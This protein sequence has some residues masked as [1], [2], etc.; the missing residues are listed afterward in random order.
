VSPDGTAT[1]Q[2][3]V[4]QTGDVDRGQQAVPSPVSTFPVIWS[5]VPLQDFENS[6]VRD[7]GIEAADGV[8]PGDLGHRPADS[9][10]ASIW[11]TWGK[12]PGN[13]LCIVSSRSRISLNLKS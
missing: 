10:S 13:D 1:I 12:T 6:F 9:K 4:N 5:A 2:V 11:R 3:A 7:A 8:C